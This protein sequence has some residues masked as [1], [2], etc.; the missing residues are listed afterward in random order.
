MA[1]GEQQAVG[2]DGIPG[3]KDTI[4]MQIHLKK[5]ARENIFNA[6]ISFSRTL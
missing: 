6:N 5:E 2:V 3:N 1:S 4:L